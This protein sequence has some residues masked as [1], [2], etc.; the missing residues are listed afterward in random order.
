MSAQLSRRFG[1]VAAYL[2]LLRVPLDERLRIGRMVE[3]RAVEFEDL[4]EPDRKV[5]LEAEAI[6]RRHLEAVERREPHTLDHLWAEAAGTSLE[7]AIAAGA[8]PPP[9]PP[10]ASRPSRLGR[11][12]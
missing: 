12:V 8:L 3:Q 9:P 5:I 11:G 4:A 6:R 1:R 2:S 10:P 7:E